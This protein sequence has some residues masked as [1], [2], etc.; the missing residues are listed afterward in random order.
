[1]LDQ[2]GHSILRPSSS[3]TS[4]DDEDEFSGLGTPGEFEGSRDSGALEVPVPLGWLGSEGV[5]REVKVL[6]RSDSGEAQGI[7]LVPG[8]V[9]LAGLA[10]F[11][12]F[13]YFSRTGRHW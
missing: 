7:I 13:R 9:R 5:L 12:Q 6:G 10:H 4:A 11:V 1:M 2:I 8:Q 3:S